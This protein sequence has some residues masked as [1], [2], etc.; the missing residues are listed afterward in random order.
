MYRTIATLLLGYD[1]ESTIVHFM[2]CRNNSQHL[3]C[4]QKCTHGESIIHSLPLHQTQP[5][6]SNLQQIEKR[7]QHLPSSVTIIAVLHFLILKR[8]S[9]IC[10]YCAIYGQN[11][12]LFALYLVMFT[13][14]L[15]LL[16]VISQSFLGYTELRRIHTTLYISW[17]C[18]ATLIKERK[19][20]YTRLTFV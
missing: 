11:W 6:K 19:L 15:R 20:N 16:T 17:T 9:L 3:S 12:T 10:Y 2:P 5:T 14:G 1:P 4:K 18:L 13:F 7:T 8:I